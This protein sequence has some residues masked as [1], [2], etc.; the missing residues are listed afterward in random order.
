MNNFDKSITNTP[1]KDYFLFTK[2]KENLKIS[3]DI[4]DYY[5]I[6]PSIV[7][8]ALSNK[9]LNPSRKLVNALS[10]NINQ[11][12]ELILRD[13]Y[14]NSFVEPCNEYVKIITASLHYNFGYAL[15][16]DDHNYIDHGEIPLI[17]CNELVPYYAVIRKNGPE[18]KYTLVFDWYSVREK[19]CIAYS[20]SNSYVY[21]THSPTIPFKDYPSFFFAMTSGLHSLFSLDSMADVKKIIVAF[22]TSEKLAYEN[23]R[24]GLNDS[25]K[26]ILPL[27]YDENAEYSIKDI[28]QI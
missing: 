19:L 24:E 12:P 13:I 22:P 17:F 28:D 16:Y 1:L 21:D 8:N 26:K 10:K 27:L 4:A 6:S 5:N 15:F 11:K 23:I 3:K 14:N 18:L 9:T 25:T 7:G 20:N 2:A